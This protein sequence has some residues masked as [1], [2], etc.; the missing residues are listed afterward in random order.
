MLP[1]PGLM[2]SFQHRAALA[3]QL[4]HIIPDAGEDI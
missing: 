2:N 1:E 3:G 4:Y